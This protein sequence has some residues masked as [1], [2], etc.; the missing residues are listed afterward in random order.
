MLPLRRPVPQG[1]WFVRIG[2]LSNPEASVVV[3]LNGSEGSAPA[4]PTTPWPAGLSTANLGVDG[5]V[6]AT[7]V[8]LRTTSDTTNVCIGSVLVGLPE[9]A[10]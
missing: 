3:T 6:D 7:S 9:V 4:L 2:Y 10:R 8:T 1:E 5:L